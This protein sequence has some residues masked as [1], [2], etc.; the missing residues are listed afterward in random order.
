MIHGQLL[1]MGERLYGDPATGMQYSFLGQSLPS[2]S[3]IV[4]RMWMLWSKP[5]CK[6]TLPDEFADFFGTASEADVRASILAGVQQCEEKYQFYDKAM[7][8]M[9]AHPSIRAYRN[10]ETTFFGIFKF[11]NR[12]SR[13]SI[14]FYGGFSC[15]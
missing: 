1:R 8:H 5:K 15:D 4:S 11:G 6:P 7:Q 14:N 2:Q 9:E 10:F 13:H 12:K 3:V